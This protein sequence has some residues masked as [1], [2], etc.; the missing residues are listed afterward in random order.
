MTGRRPQIEQDE[1][2]SA[3][4]EGELDASEQASFERRLSEDPT[5]RTEYDSFRQLLSGAD[6]A[7]ADAPVPDLMPGIRAKLKQRRGLLKGDR[8][9]QLRGRG[10]IQPLLLA[11]VLV[12]LLLMLWMVFSTLRILDSGSTAIEPGAIPAKPPATDSDH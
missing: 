6:R 1:L 5:L 12:T 10:R 2:F 9:G 3:A 8:F 11:M 7:Y 4:Y